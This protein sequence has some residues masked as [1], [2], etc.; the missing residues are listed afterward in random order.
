[1]H[2]AACPYLCYTALGTRRTILLVAVLQL[3]WPMSANGESKVLS[4]LAI[5]TLRCV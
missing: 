3:S 2:D 5:E 1:M 4:L